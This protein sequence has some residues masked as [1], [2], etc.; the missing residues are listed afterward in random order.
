V[1]HTRHL[2]GLITV[3]IASVLV[4]GSG[5]VKI[6]PAA[7]A[8]PAAATLT[9]ALRA[10]DYTLHEESD[11]QT[12]I[13]MAEDFGSFGVPGE[14]ELPARTFLIALPPATQVTGVHFETPEVVTLPDQYRLAPVG[15]AM[16][17][18]GDAD[19]A[20]AHWEA[21]H[22][23]AYAT[24]DVYPS[25]TGQYLGQGQWRRY[26]Y[27]RVA[28]HPFSYRPLSGALSFHPTLEVTI[29]YRP[30][31]ADSPARREF[32][33]LSDDRVLDDVISRHM[34]NFDQAR[35]W[36]ETPGTAPPA[37]QA[38]SL[39]DYVIVVQND[40]T[41]TVVNPFK[42]WKESLGHTVNVVT[43]EWIHAN[44]SG[45]DVA[46]EVWNF[47]HDK[48]PSGEWGI[49]YVM[50][51]GDLQ[52]IPTRRVYYADSGWGLRSDHFFA[53]LS[54]GPT[55]EDVW[56]RD[57][58]VRWGELHDDEMTVEPDVLVGRIPL[59]NTTEVGN[60]V[61]AM[62]TFEQ[63]NGSWKHRALLAGGYN[64]I[65]S[66]T[67]KTDNAV[68]LEMVRTELLDPNGWA[69]T[70]IYEQSGLGTSTYTGTV[71]YDTSQANVITGWN[72]NAHGFALLSDHGN[73][74]GLSGHVWQH[75]TLTVTN[76]VDSGEW[77][78]SNLFKITD[79]PS[80]TTTHP[81]I[82]LLLGCSS[83]ILVGPPWPLP[84]Q[85]MS[86]PGNYTEN[87]GGE[88]LAHGAAAGVVGFYSPVPYRSRWSQLNDGNEH[89]LGY[90]FTENL[91]QD[92]YTLGQSVFETKIRY[93]DKFW[94][95][96]YQ[97]FHWALNLF[98]DPSMILEGYDDSAKGSNKTIHTGAVYAY[99]TD[100]DDNGD[101]YVAVSTQPS[102]TDGEIK[103]YK[104]T[105]HGETWAL[106]KTI[107]HSEPINAVDVIVGRWAQDEF[108]SSYVHVFFTDY[109]GSVIDARIDMATKA[110]SQTTIASESSS[111]LPA[112]A[113]ARDPM[114]MPSAFNLYVTWD[115]DSGT[116]HQVKVARSTVN[117][118]SWSNKFAYDNTQQ[119][120]ID[121]G[122]WN[123]VYLV[124]VADGFPSHV[125]VN[126]STDRGAS[127]G[128]WTNLTSGDEADYH[129][130]PVVASSTEAA[131]PTVWVAY[132]YY[133][134]VTFG[135]ADLRLPT[136]PTAGATG[137]RTGRSVP[138]RGSTSSCPTWWGIAPAPAAG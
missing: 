88:L 74:D 109:A 21:S 122:P 4:L 85:T 23:R 49:R 36:Y 32:E 133:E 16:A 108:L 84:D 55:S 90:Y 18:P 61:Q 72:A 101:M 127:W 80:L 66:A 99:G 77:V 91:I 118:N 115:A 111:N 97:P 2:N 31:E 105:N 51:V 65:D 96:N 12:R 42:T 64:D 43:L 6:D 131:I 98:G 73:W 68:M 76:Q 52:V 134:S 89:T 7:P 135:A 92:H 83:S 40:A 75:D 123:R 25:Q 19:R 79:V 45:V 59:N 28:F 46:E 62:I 11:G 56:N 22:G 78:W 119:P 63:D 121:A 124:A 38:N 30:A 120:H 44:Y 14:P 138:N 60:A 26:T 37:A 39:Y 71:D 110:H 33:R 117:G 107:G 82:V 17:A 41:A 69:Y 27:A 94:N 137:P 102:D 13:H 87:T 103:V 106:W 128:G 15:P 95:N 34:V 104:S 70:R 136:A 47:L 114:S 126:R 125:H 20:M 9:I 50:L 113:A 24:D 8:E 112:I 86:D 100:N 53:K 67:L 29:E 81:S 58:D 54:G 3:L 57:G 1:K 5:G 93:T 48:Y 130:A 132:N 129:G 116:S 35:A 10:G